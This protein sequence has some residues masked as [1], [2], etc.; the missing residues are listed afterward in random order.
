MS[1]QPTGINEHLRPL[2]PQD[3]IEDYQR[4][5]TVRQ[6]C[7]GHSWRQTALPVITGVITSII[8]LLLSTVYPGSFGK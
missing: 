2:E 1:Q 6:E 5:H 7:R 8:T 3:A 4:E